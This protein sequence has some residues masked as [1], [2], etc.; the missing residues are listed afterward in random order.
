MICTVHLWLRLYDGLVVVLD[1]SG[2]C[3]IATSH[4]RP[5]PFPPNLARVVT[6]Q[7]RQ[8]PYTDRH[9][10]MVLGYFG[11][12]HIIYVSLLLTNAIAILNEERFL[13]KSG[14]SLASLPRGIWTYTLDHLRY[15]GERLD[16]GGFSSLPS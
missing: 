7:Y 16:I 1:R 3:H 14:S 5:R 2:H 10:T 9:S 4:L 12:G 11:F 15:Q 13:A 6:C 8:Y